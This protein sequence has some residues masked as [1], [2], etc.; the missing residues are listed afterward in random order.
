MAITPKILGQV[1]DA[2]SEAQLYSCP[3]ATTATVTS[4]VVCNRAASATTFHI[5]VVNGAGVATTSSWLHFDVPI[6]GNDSFIA[7][8]GATLEAD[9]QLRVLAG[10]A[11]VTFNAF[12]VEEA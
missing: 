11:T 12:G 4:I 5:A 9:D 6:D 10:A 8:I 7:T 3:A 2:S 1:P